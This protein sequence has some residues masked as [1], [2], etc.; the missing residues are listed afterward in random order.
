MR[1][2]QSGTVEFLGLTALVRPPRWN[3]VVLPHEGQLKWNCGIPGADRTG[4]TTQTELGG[5][6]P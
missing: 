2:N 1:D 5:T 3:L 6:A 4:E